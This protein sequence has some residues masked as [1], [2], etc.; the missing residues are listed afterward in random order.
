MGIEH[1]FG[2]KQLYKIEL[3]MRCLVD[4]C[5]LNGLLGNDSSRRMVFALQYHATV[6]F[7]KCQHFVDQACNTFGIIDNLHRH[8]AFLRLIQFGISSCQHLCK[9]TYN[10]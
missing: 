1:L 10:I 3:D 7:G 4:T 2:P 9:T 8:I 6:N 5:R